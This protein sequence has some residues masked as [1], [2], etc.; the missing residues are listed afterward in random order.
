MVTRDCTGL[1]RSEWVRDE[2]STPIVA[3]AGLRGLRETVAARLISQVVH[4]QSKRLA[5]TL[6]SAAFDTA[7][8]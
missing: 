7:T 6:V 8:G 5:L 2:P 4:F 1:G 3:F